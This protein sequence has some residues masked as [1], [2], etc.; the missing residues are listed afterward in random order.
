MSRRDYIEEIL[1]KK[2]RSR[3]KWQNSNSKLFQLERNFREI[4]K[5]NEID[6]SQYSLFLVGIVTCL[7]VG[8]RGAIQKLVDKGTPYT[9]RIEK[10][11]DFLKIDLNV[12]KALHDRKVSFG[13][14]VSHLLPANNIENIISHFGVLLDSSFTDKL[15]TLRYFQ[16][17]DLSKYLEGSGE[18]NVEEEQPIEEELESTNLMIDDVNILITRMNEVFT[19]RHIIV[20]E[21]NFEVVS[22]KEELDSYFES[23]IIFDNALN[24][25]V[26]QTINPNKPRHTMYSA[27]IESYNADNATADM[28]DLVITLND[29]VRDEVVPFGP[30]EKVALENSQKCFLEYLEAELELEAAAVR[31]GLGYYWNYITANL[32]KELCLQR[33]ERLKEIKKYLLEADI[34]S[35]ES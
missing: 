34:D 1:A 22:T 9:E 31:P 15:K 12:T 32:K 3:N 4:K 7:E 5:N 17:P 2:I 10:F 20:H 19:K 18:E 23:A 28:Q 11:K 6:I 26:E 8:V 25:L 14:L 21:A 35:D 13:E 30:S 27:V 24:E 16:E 29:I 33:I